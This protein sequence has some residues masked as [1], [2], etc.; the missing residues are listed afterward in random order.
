MKR[1]PD[2]FSANVAL[3]LLDAVLAGGVIPTDC[4]RSYAR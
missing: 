1:V 3:F 2:A 4:W